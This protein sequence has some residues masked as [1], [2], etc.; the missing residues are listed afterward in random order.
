MEKGVFFFSYLSVD[1][2]FSPLFSKRRFD[3]CIVDEASQILQPI[4]LGPLSFAQTFVL[5]GDHYQL[6]PLVR[7]TMARERGMDESL[8]KRLCE[9]HPEAII[10]LCYQYRMNQDIM[11]LSNYIVYNQ[12]LQCGSFSVATNLLNTIDMSRLYSLSH[13]LSVTCD[14]T[15]WL[16]QTIRPE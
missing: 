2:F 1:V 3:Y 16:Y 12:R 13:K 9:A 10:P 15:C 6:P 5:V 14:S 4:C 8:F 11:S 7:H